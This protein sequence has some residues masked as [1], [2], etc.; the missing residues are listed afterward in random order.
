MITGR[1]HLLP[2]LSA[3]LLLCACTT[4][5]PPESGAAATAS[6]TEA[7][8]DSV[9]ATLTLRDKVGQM[10]QLNITLVCH[11]DEA[12]GRYVFDEDKLRGLIATYRVGS[13]L[14]V[15]DVSGHTLT[16]EQ[17]AGVVSHVQAVSRELLGIPT[18]YGV[19]H[20][21]GA[22]YT[23]G[24]T[25]LPQPINQAATFDTALV[26]RGAQMTAYESRAGDCPWLFNPTL[27]LGRD[28]RWPRLWESFGE[29]A[30]VNALMGEAQVRGYQGADREHLGPHN[31]GACVKHYLGYGLPFTGKDR[32]PAIIAPNMLREKYFEPFRRTLQAGAL[33][34]MANSG[35]VNGMPVHASH[36]FLTE[37]VKQDLQWDGMIVT[38]WAD[39]NSLYTREH[40]AADRTEAIKMAINAGIDMTMDPYDPTFCDILE[41]LVR[42][43]EVSSE[44]VDDACRRVLRLKMRLGLFDRPD[45][46]AEDFPLFASPEHEALARQAALESEVLLKNEGALLPLRPGARV[47]LC[48]PA[49]HHK[50]SWHG[51]WT[52]SWQGS[53]VEQYEAPY[54]SFYEALAERLGRDRVTLSPGVRFDDNGKWQDELPADFAPALAAAAN[55]DVIMAC[56]GENSYTELEG[57]VDDLTLSQQQRDL[58]KALAATGKPIVLVLVGGRPR[59]I[60]DIEPLC[61]AVVDVMLPGNYGADALAKLLTGDENFSARLP[62]T[63]PKFINSLTTYD[64]KVS[65]VVGTMAG[66]YD[67][68]ARV[69]LL[70]PFGH[71]L[72]YTTYKYSDLRCEPATFG[73]GDTLS[74]S[75]TV[76]NTGARAGKEAVL[77][78]SSDLV[79]SITPDCRRLRAFGKVELLPGEKRTVTFRLPATDLA[80]VDDRGL[81][82]LQKGAFTLSCADLA[83]DLECTGTADLG[84]VRR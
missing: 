55:A 38:D 70:W 44:R 77:L 14:N 84:Q 69:S 66:A 83:T 4:P 11:L 32:T 15:P 67:Y 40:V 61:Q 59:I 29:D 34:L 73:P 7:R 26:R 13:W 37:W 63:Y 18:L 75:V 68:S 46:R 81:W 78:Y 30:L 2:A 28:Q 71:G 22:S 6:A 65:E 49:A 10:L 79:A 3:V 20:N 9:M 43:G 51:G 50:R 72:S 23:V 64:Y 19:D 48:G 54:H 62:F 58:V 21:H 45:T 56:L 60:R 42:R 74:V 24:A 53:H 33:S 39:I 5:A 1:K 35:S 12:T 36:T 31:V 17:W 52:Y 25:L 76:A 57:N 8:V 80:F 82:T 16:P 47:M 27:D 41:G